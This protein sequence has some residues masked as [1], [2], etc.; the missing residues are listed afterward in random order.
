MKPIRDGW[1]GREWDLP[2][3][4]FIR[5]GSR[6]MSAEDVQ[7]GGETEQILMSRI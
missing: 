6:Q 4:W 2:Q 5:E 3:A 1:F 7:D